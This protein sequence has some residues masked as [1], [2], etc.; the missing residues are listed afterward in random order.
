MKNRTRIYNE[1]NSSRSFCVYRRVVY[2]I[3]GW[4]GEEGGGGGGV[5]SMVFASLT[6]SQISV[7]RLEQ[8]MPCAHSD[9]GGGGSTTSSSLS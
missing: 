2:K 5:Q 1:G 3:G 4:G 9:S 8:S 7:L 6:L